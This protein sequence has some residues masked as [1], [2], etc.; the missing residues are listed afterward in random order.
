VVIYCLPYFSL[1]HAFGEKLGKFQYNKVIPI[2]DEGMI[3]ELMRIFLAICS[4][5]DKLMMEDVIKLVNSEEKISTVSCNSCGNKNSVLMFTLTVPENYTREEKT[6]TK[7]EQGKPPEPETG[8][9][10]SE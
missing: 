10:K 7:A 1:R 9:N 6:D 2:K 3:S 5:C 4:I 8:E